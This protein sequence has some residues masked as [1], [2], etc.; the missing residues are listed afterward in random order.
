MI[1]E[2][3]SDDG[4]ILIG[5]YLFFIVAIIIYFYYEYKKS[6]ISKKIV[7]SSL[8]IKRLNRENF[9]F[10]ER[11]FQGSD[12]SHEEKIPREMMS[13]LADVGTGL[14]RIRK[15][16]AL[17]AKSKTE[18][19]LTSIYRP[20]DSTWNKLMQAG[21]EIKG[22]D[23]DIIKGGEALQIIAFQKSRSLNRDTVIETLRPTIHYR[24]KIVQMGEVIVGTPESDGISDD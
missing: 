14:W 2:A 3:I 24:G 23:G 13:L 11:D 20:F 16:L 6:Q 1:I 15:M 22:H 5:M 18:G 21:L 10:A 19:E 17:A 9:K 7:E 4:D 12:S 8:E